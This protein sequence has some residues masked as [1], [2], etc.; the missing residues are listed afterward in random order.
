MTRRKEIPGFECTKCDQM[1]LGLDSFHGEYSISH[2]EV[3]NVHLCSKCL[4]ETV[5]LWNGEPKLIE[6]HFIKEI[7]KWTSLH[8]LDRSADAKRVANEVAL[9]Y[10]RN[11]VTFDGYNDRSGWGRDLT[12]L[13]QTARKIVHDDFRINCEEQ[14]RIRVL[15]SR[16]IV[17][18]LI[19]LKGKDVVLEYDSDYYHGTEEQKEKDSYKDFQLT[20]YGRYNVVRVSEEIIKNEKPIFMSRVLDAMHSIR[21]RKNKV[22]KQ[23]VPMN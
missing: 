16:Y 15:S 13:E 5:A 1:Y 4:A 19:H 14:V 18:G 20:H 12:G 2:G 23:L 22:S 3:K 6:R 7:E 21:Q 11:C 8:A 17:D 10:I 9:D